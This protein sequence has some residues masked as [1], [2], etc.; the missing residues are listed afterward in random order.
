MYDLWRSCYISMDPQQLSMYLKKTIC[1][2]ENMQSRHAGVSAYFWHKKPRS[3]LLKRTSFFF[4]LLQGAAC[5]TPLCS[6]YDQ[7]VSHKFRACRSGM[8]A[9]S[10]PMMNPSQ[11]SSLTP[12]AC[13][14]FAD[15]FHSR[16]KDISRVK[17]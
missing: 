16:T 11:M 6:S 7:S 4:F 13:M 8:P 17:N 14:H 5:W 12:C 1:T 9:H 15:F 10:L 2:S 3:L